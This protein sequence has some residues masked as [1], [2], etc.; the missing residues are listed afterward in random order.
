MEH[1]H[2]IAASRNTTVKLPVHALWEQMGFLYSWVH[3]A[4]SAQPV[5]QQPGKTM[6]SQSANRTQPPAA[7]NPIRPGHKR[8]SS[9]SKTMLPAS[10]PHPLIANSS[11]NLNR[12]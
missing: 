12:D 1:E 2:S 6:R 7:P 11:P 10:E 4:V 3:P 9:L 8:K 5:R